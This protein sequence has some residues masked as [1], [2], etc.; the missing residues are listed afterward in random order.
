[1]SPHHFTSTLLD[2]YATHGRDLPWRHTRD[3]YAIWLSEIILQ[4][5]R[6]A[7]GMAY[8]QR[9]MA[10]YPTVDDLAAASEDEVLKLWQG[11]GYYS[12]ARNLH[13]AAR[14]IV[15]MGHFPNTIDSIKQLKGVGDYTA[16]AIASFAF[17]IPAAAVDGNFYRV[18]ARVYGIDTPIN[19]TKGNKLFQELAD[20]LIG[21]L[22]PNPSLNA[23][24]MD[25]GAT[26]CVPKS[27]ACSTCPLMEECEAFRQGRV[28]E[29]P[30]KLKTTKV[31]TRHMAYAYLRCKGQ[32][33]MRQRGS[34]DIWQGLWEPVMLDEGMVE[35]WKDRL[36][37]IARQVKHVLTHRII[38][39]DLYL[40]ESPMRPSLPDGYTWIDE[41]DIDRYA[42]PRLVEILL[43]LLPGA[44]KRPK[45]SHGLPKAK[46]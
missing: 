27:P 32:T 36:V 12:R 9:F 19:S 29:L 38:L 34:G 5:T 3:P 22:S 11:L 25:F 31:Q 8:W 14:Q 46:H 18:L 2:W 21:G 6:V 16:A 7:Q 39:A 43:G 33:A 26:Q 42:V 28:N 24:M 17:G 30:V 37:P 40:L 4:Q 35:Q 10:A 41:D 13:K 44:D 45:T 15:E 1:M 23:A 20:S